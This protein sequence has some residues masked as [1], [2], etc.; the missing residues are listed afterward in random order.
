MHKVEVT[1]VSALSR[2]VD[3]RVNICSQSKNVVHVHIELSVTKKTL[4]TFTLN[5]LLHNLRLLGLGTK[6]IKEKNNIRVAFSV[7][8]YSCSP[9][10]GNI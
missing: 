8:R 5:G 7:T 4:Y 9:P 10:M 1:T 3:S 2:H 6:Y